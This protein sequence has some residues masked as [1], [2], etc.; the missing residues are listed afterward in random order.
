MAQSDLLVRFGADVEPL[1]K[2]ARKA[3][4]S[5]GQVKDKVKT[6]SKAF[7]AATTAATALGS[8][9]VKSSVQSAKEVKNLSVAAGLGTK[10]FQ[11]YAFAAKTAGIEQ[12][13][14]SDILKDVNDRVGDFLSTGGGPMLDFFENIA[15]KVGVTAE[16]FKKLN[17]REALQ[18]YVDSLEKANVSQQ[19]FTFY[20]EA[21]ASDATMLLPL[22]KNNGAAMNA[23]AGEADALGLALSDIDNQNLVDAGA[24]V[25]KLSGIA[26]RSANIFASELAPIVTAVAKDIEKHFLEAGGSTE[27]SLRKVANAAADTFATVLEE[28]A[29]VVGV[30][31]QNPDIA[32]FGILGYAVLGKKGAVLG[33][34]VGAMAEGIKA[35]L[36]DMGLKS[37]DA[38]DPI[39]QRLE[40][41]QTKMSNIDKAIATMELFGDV[42]PEVMDDFIEKYTL[43]QLEVS[44][45]KGQLEEGT[46]AFQEYNE[47]FDAGTESSISF[48]E[49]MQ[50]A[51]QSIRDARA[52]QDEGGIVSE[53][54]G[55]STQDEKLKSQF[56]AFQQFRENMSRV[57]KDYNDIDY[58]A[59][60]A[61][62]ERKTA[63]KKAHWK[64]A[65][66][67]ASQAFGNLS[68]LMSSE[69]KKQFE[70]GKAAAKAQ[71]VIDTYA[72][73]QSAYKS[74][75]GIPVVGPALGAAAAGAAVVAGMARLSAINSTSFGGGS[76]NPSAGGSASGID[77]GG[78][79]IQGQQAGQAGQAGQSSTLFVEGLDDD[80]LLTG[81]FVRNLIG[82]INEA[83]ADG[84]KVILT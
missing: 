74:L 59:V 43:M 36:V 55:D 68:S 79:A 62:E 11:E 40:T 45:L 13:K 26:S 71:T 1:K 37:S 18:L 76:I 75:A 83:H 39:N 42:P 15:P 2:G 23:L 61:N 46:P 54:D 69:N 53:D 73:A 56:D 52:A 84:T 35:T 29:R 8:V 60:K 16:Q 44:E 28:A 9:I 77:Q 65:L 67:G 4:R 31:E 6:V 7:V 17:S 5:L 24:A 57:E 70:I 47:M 49:A 10:E 64:T 58:A 81:G 20:M 27:E 72:S 21:M 41:L 3:S 82:K 38:I 22:L 50:K 32:K 12:E 34:T 19:E 30:I 33:A 80:A 63:L 25:N 66:S 14:F 78:A 48:A 51:A